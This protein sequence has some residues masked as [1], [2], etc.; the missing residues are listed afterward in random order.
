MAPK[1]AQGRT[2]RPDIPILNDRAMIR[3]N[4]TAI[5][6][7]IAHGRHGLRGAVGLVML[8][9]L[10]GAGPSPGVAAESGRGRN[11]EIVEGGVVREVVD[12]D[13]VRLASGTQIRL[14]GIQAPKLPLGRANFRAW[15]L[16]EEAKA[17]LAG[18]VLSR[19]V[20]LRYGGRRID[21]HGRLL[22]HLYDESGLWAQGEMLSRGLARVYTFGDNRW[23][24]AAMLALEEAAR[25]ARRGIWRRRHYRVRTV[26]ETPQWIGTFQ[27]VEGRVLA[28]A[29]VRGRG[30][31][32]FGDDWRSDFT[33]SVPPRFR[34][35]FR[36][37]G[38]P[39]SVYA[40]KRIRVR[41]WLR[42]YN[43]PMMEATHP[44]QI[45]MLDE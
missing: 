10:G 45:E 11:P 36:Q 12:G 33:V 31:L 34:R 43:G 7:R 35:L 24:A 41:G 20:V 19:Q 3:S 21:R 27:L 13:T 44:E 26:A 38:V 40:G 18:L 25:G 4:W 17:A 23:Q 22:A 42:N 2:R 28:A 29:V 14:V 30:Y 6:T 37:A 39:I 32:N 8:V 9:A 5:L 1:G 15:P 16:A